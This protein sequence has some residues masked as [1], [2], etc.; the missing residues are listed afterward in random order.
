[1]KIYSIFLACVLFA[2]IFVYILYQNYELK[3]YQVF[4][5][6]RLGETHE[7][8]RRI[9]QDFRDTT[10][11]LDETM[12]ERDDF[13]QNYYAEKKRMEDFALQIR[14]IQSTVGVLEKI[15]NTDEELLKKYSKVYFLNENYTPEK[16]TEIDSHYTHEAGR[17][18]LA[19][20]GVLPHLK[21]IMENAKNE[22]IDIKIISAYRSF[23]EQAFLKISYRV[24]YGT[25][26]NQFSA[27]QGYSEHQLG[28]AVDF[29]TSSTDA[30]F[31]SFNKTSAYSWLLENAYKY[32]FVLSY[33]EGNTYYKFEPWHWR[34]VGRNLAEKL[35][36]DGKYFYDLDQRVLDTY[37]I[38]LFD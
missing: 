11:K 29:T 16:L 12:R 19:H 20:E 14:T 27:D 6:G 37:L 35:H 22:N 33:P 25:G 36:T 3:R 23:D 9:S 7:M 10:Q 28:T 32:G 38:S 30:D 5:E 31:Y 4:L 26:A 13:E 17:T 18:L 15:Q 8:F 34:F 21:N 1:M 2:G 24:V